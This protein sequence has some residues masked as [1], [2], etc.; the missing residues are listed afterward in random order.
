MNGIVTSTSTEFDP[1]IRFV[2]PIGTTNLL[3]TASEATSSFTI[4]ASGMGQ[5]VGL[6]Y[7]VPPFTVGKI[8]ANLQISAMTSQDVRDLNDL[9]MGMLNASYREQVREYERI[10][11]SANVSLWSWAFGGGAEASYEKTHEKMSSMGLTE[12]QIGKLMDAFLERA[13]SM[14]TV[15]LDF[16]VNNTMDFA[17]EGNFFMYTI[18]GEVTTEKGT[19]QYRMLADAGSAG[20]PPPTGGGAAATGGY[21]PLN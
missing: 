21:I 16:T 13:K 4:A 9:A 18:L 5:A 7:S 8:K 1:N 12:D 3:A 14:N 11:A 20:G 19:A 2:D 15:E 17:V 6:A 10:S